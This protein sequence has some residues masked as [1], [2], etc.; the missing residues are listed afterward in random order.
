MKNFTSCIAAASFMF[1]FPFTVLSQTAPAL[2]S[3][4]TFVLFT[5]NGQF[6][7]TSSST[8][9]T[10]N[11]GNLAGAVS[12]F[13]PGSLSG[14]KHFGDAA[15][16]QASTDLNAAY[17]D[18]AGR[19]CGIAHGVGFG[20]GETLTPGT[21]CSLAA[22]TLNGNLFLD[23]VGNAAAVFIIKVNGTFSAAPG[24]QVVLVNG[25][26]PCN[27]FWQI[28]G[29]VDLNNSVFRGS[30]LV[31]GAIN[32]NAGTL[33]YG[34]ALATT[35]NLIF[36]NI[37]ATICD[38][39]VL[40]LKLLKFDIAKT[41]N[42]NIDIS[43]LTGSETNMLRY[44][45]E[46][47]VNATTFIKV[48]TVASKSSSYPTRYSFQDVNVFKTGTRFYRLKMI[49]KDASFSYS[50]IKSIKFSETRLGLIDMF[51]NPAN[52]IINLSVNAENDGRVSLTI[53]NMQGQQVMHKTMHIHKGINNIS[54]DIHTLSKAGY[55]VS[56]KNIT[57][58]KESRQ[59]FQKL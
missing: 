46:T 48:G 42:N 17:A 16:T 43:W 22:S 21:Y 18:L 24:S 56:V 51:P 3:A 32:L 7:S 5:G 20:S 39:T 50:G 10:G 8:S 57:T 23:A 40:P 13:P 37:V 41:P 55:V 25:A 36:Q 15:A 38:L 2:N 12:A 59:K 4:S 31:N 53:S 54:E 44:E 47:S 45:I 9:V 35:G 1:V 49:E 58:G 14:T 34:R 26:V 19:A 33:L 11:V 29:A 52:N 28:N 27:V 6:T 30:M